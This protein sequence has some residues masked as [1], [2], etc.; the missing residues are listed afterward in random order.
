M[1]VP[2]E[3]QRVFD[4]WEEAGRPPQPAVEWQRARWIERY[5]A[6]TA[7]FED[8][9]AHL[10]RQLVRARVVN[11][12]ATP[13]GMF[14]AMVTTYAWGWSTSPVGP[15]R[16]GRVLTAGVAE[17]GPRLLAARERVLTD[18]PLAGYWSLARE[19]RVPGLGPAFGTKFLYFCSADGHR[20]LILDELVGTWLTQRTA[21]KVRSSGYVRRRYERYLDAL[22]EWGADLNVDA[23]QIEELIFSDEARRRDLPGW[24]G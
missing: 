4:E 15:A 13:A 1:A 6:L 7:N 24:G 17:V 16:A 22:A 19:S 5:P 12:P 20:A 11:S 21:V 2:D 14:D 23:Q 10:N 8:I 3:V 9:P 18:G